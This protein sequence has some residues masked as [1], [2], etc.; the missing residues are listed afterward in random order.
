MNIYSSE[1]VTA[2][3]NEQPIGPRDSRSW[4]FMKL[5]QIYYTVFPPGAPFTNMV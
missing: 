1:D 5:L 3:T 4:D 2:S